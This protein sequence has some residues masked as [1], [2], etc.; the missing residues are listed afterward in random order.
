M[1]ARDR[2]YVTPRRAPDDTLR[3]A[4]DRPRR[5]MPRGVSEAQIPIETQEDADRAFFLL[6]AKP[7]GEA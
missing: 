3:A 1:A 7:E 2:H 5:P 6:N 4:A